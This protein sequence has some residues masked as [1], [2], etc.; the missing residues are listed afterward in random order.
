MAEVC[1]PWIDGQDVVTCCDADVSN[2]AD[3]DPYADAAGDLLFELSARLFPGICSDTVRPCRTRCGC[4]WQILSRGH[5]VWN[6]NVLDPYYGW[7][8]CGADQQ[9]GCFPLSRVLLAGYVTAVSEVK[10]DGDIVDPDTYRVDE[11]Q[12]LTRV[13]L[14]PDDPV[15]VWP[16]CQDMSLP[17]TEHGTFSVTYTYGRDVPQA[18]VLAASQLACEMWKQC[19]GLECRLPQGTARVIRAGVVVERTPFISWGFERGGRSIPRGW[20]TGMPLVD[21]FL[22]GYNPTGLAREPVFWSPTSYLEYAQKLGL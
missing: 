12:W 5:I 14:T 17:D 11:N 4:P 19:N 16:G 15:A 22:N 1:T 9:C 3:L 7:W 8:N 21:A 10:I 2:P 13:R 18:G 20:N 6:P